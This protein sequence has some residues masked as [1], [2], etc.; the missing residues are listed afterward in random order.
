MANDFETQVWDALKTVRF[1]GMSRDIVSFGFVHTVKACAG[2]VSVDLQMSTHNPAAAEKVREEA[3][4]VLRAL[5]EVQEARVNINVT[6][7]PTREES[8]QKAIAQ[9]SSLI[10]GVRHVVAVASGKGG[11]GKSTVAANLAIALA[12]LGHKVGLLDSDI[13]GPSVPMMLGITE[14]PRVIGNR[15]LPFEKYGLRVMSLG[16][17][18]EEDTPVIWRGPM[19]MRAIEQMLGDVEW[20][21]LDYM[22]LDLPPGTGDAQLTVTQRIPLAGAVIV[23]TPQDVALIDARKGLAMFRKVNVPV[24][25]IVENM[26]T[27]V[28]PHCGQETDIFKKGGGHRTADLLGTAFL[29]SIPLDAQIVLG[30]DA[31]VPIVVAEPKGRHADAFRHVAESVVDEVARQEE[32]KPKLTIV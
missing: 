20:G 10:P 28:C 21:E 5:P 24:I 13:Y 22:V 29:G 17:I 14:K 2:V 15:I 6:K 9:D 30:G 4:R 8:A 25:G 1:P 26:S 32:L 3:E 31:G 7:P 11:V 18:L 19:V 27:F 16:F 12:Q 23:T